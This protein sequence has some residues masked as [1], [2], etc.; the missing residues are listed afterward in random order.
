MQ[1]VIEIQETP[2]FAANCHLPLGRTTARHVLLESSGWVILK[3]SHFEWALCNTQ[4]QQQRYLSSLLS[5]C[6]LN[7]APRF[8]LAPGTPT[9]SQVQV[10]Q[11]GT[12]PYGKAVVRPQGVGTS[13]FSMS[14]DSSRLA[15]SSS[16]FDMSSLERAL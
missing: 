11:N 8:S 3:V 4:E 14:P 15:S 5:S 16:G 13:I 2:H 10:A 7:S 9:T 12:I 1:I 6:A